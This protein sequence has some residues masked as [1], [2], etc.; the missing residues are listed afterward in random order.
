MKH[1][2]VPEDAYLLHDFFARVPL[3]FNA[4]DAI[5]SDL[6]AKKKKKRNKLSKS[7]RDKAT[8]LYFEGAARG[9]RPE[10]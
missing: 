9:Q 10:L 1:L 5:H 8:Y 3:K 2:Q 7:L 6:F 4:D